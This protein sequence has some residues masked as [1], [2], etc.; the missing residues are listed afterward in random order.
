MLR[1]HDFLATHEQNLLLD[2]FARDYGKGFFHSHLYGCRLYTLCE[3]KKRATQALSSGLVQSWPEL[4]R[5]ARE[6]EKAKA[7]PS[8]VEQE[9]G[10]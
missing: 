10:V 7:A 4:V 5:L 2:S 8:A 3:R 1:Q 6:G 9:L